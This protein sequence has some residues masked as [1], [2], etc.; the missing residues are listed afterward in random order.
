LDHPWPL[1]NL[2]LAAKTSLRG[3]LFELCERAYYQG[4]IVVAAKYNPPVRENGLPAELSSCIGADFGHYQ[5]PC[6]YEFRSRMPVEFK[7]R[8]EGVKAPA[9]GG[10]YTTVRGTSFATAAIS[11]LCALLLG[12]CPGLEPFEIK[13]MLRRLAG[14]ETKGG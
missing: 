13:T 4:Q 11:G 10:G 5:T 6:D 1:L 12:A 9:P 7:A 8:G 14:A 2:S 3:H